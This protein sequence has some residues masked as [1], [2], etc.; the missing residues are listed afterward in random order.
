MTFMLF[1][2]EA[3]LGLTLVSSLVLGLRVL[4]RRGRGLEVQAA[5]RLV[6]ASLI[7]VLTAG[8]LALAVGIL[9]HTFV[10]RIDALAAQ[11]LFDHRAPWLDRLM[12]LM[13]A[14]GDGPARTAATILLAA[15]LLWRR[16]FRW[17]L[18]L[19]LVM[20]AAAVLT[21]VLKTTFHLA[22]PSLLYS[23]AD[24]F[25]FPSGHATSAA[26]LYLLL[27]WIVGRSTTGVGRVLFAALALAVVLLTALSR[28]YLGAHW[29]SDVLAGLALGSALGL[30]G[31]LVA[32][33]DDRRSARDEAWHAAVIVAVLAGVALVLGPKA[34]GKAERLYAP[35]LN[36]P[37]NR[38]VDPGHL[39]GAPGHRIIAPPGV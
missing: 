17:A 10:V 31:V 11:A 13:S 6:C 16:R 29:L 2:T 26:A 37:A 32:A 39:G 23:G 28:I 25:S 38:V 34:Y 4:A 5:R 36:R 30:A 1:V 9:G 21:P 24:A 15:F 19:G 3:C 20:V 33:G 22:R 18:A 35:Y 12:M 7:L 27:T 8:V 14:L